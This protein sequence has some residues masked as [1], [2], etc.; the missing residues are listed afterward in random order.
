MVEWPE[1]YV[2]L[3]S[4]NPEINSYITTAHSAV[5]KKIYNSWLLQKDIIQKRLQSA[6]T[7]I[8][9]SINIW[10]SPNNHLLL[11]IYSHFI[12]SQEKLINALLSLRTVASHSR[13]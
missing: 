8:H 11:A 6:L 5:S 3:Q 7:S 2:L 12:N 9:L 1:F 13:D 4:I 10:T